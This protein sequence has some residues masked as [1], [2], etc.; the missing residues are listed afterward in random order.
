MLKWTGMILI[1]ACAVFAAL[2]TADNG[3]KRLEIYEGLI[4]Y[5]TELRDGITRL[6]LPLGELYMRCSSDVLTSPGFPS[7]LE[8]FGWAD[9]LKLS[10]IAEMLDERSFAALCELGAV[11]GK[12][13]AAEQ[14]NACNYCISRLQTS[15]SEIR[16]DAP[17]KTR[18]T[19]SLC[20]LG[21]VAIIIILL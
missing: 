15:F 13:D 4:S 21:G 8:R 2:K 9:A 7:M 5:I 18:M 11:I 16:T 1:A 17:K 6:R 19:S 14:E 3:K 10:G 12:S 20:L